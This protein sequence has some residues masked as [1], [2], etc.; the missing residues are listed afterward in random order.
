M[1]RTALRHA[2]TPTSRRANLNFKHRESHWHMGMTMKSTRRH[3]EPE[4]GDA[5]RTAHRR[6][7]WQLMVGF[8]EFP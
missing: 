3:A 1:T 8:E 5:T 6:G 7:H 4:F 2:V